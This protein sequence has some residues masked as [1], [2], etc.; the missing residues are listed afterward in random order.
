MTTQAQL[1]QAFTIPDFLRA[2]DRLP[3]LPDGYHWEG[4]AIVMKTEKHDVPAFEVVLIPTPENWD[5]LMKFLS[6]C[7]D[8]GVSHGRDIERNFIAHA[9]LTAAIR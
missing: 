5:I 4:K 7:M 6:D 8:M 3:V 2:D 1:D 9:L